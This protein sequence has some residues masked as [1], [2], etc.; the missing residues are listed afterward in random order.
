MYTACLMWRG[1]VVQ[2]VL[3][4]AQSLSGSKE[5]VMCCRERAGRVGSRVSAL[6]P[7]LWELQRAIAAPEVHLQFVESLS[8]TLVLLAKVHHPCH[9]LP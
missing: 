1:H 2:A 7:A 9:D 6:V 5:A 4:L 3:G 8:N